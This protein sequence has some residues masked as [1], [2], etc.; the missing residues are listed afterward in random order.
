VI[1]R[2]SFSFILFVAGVAHLTRPDLFDPAIPFSFKIEINVA[3]GILEI[4]LAL[5]LCFSRTKDFAARLSA[6]WLLLLVPVHVYVSVFEIPILGVSHPAILW[7]RTAFQFVLYFWALSIQDKGWMIAQRWSDVL[8]LHYE[9]DASELQ[10]I[11]PYPVD[12][13]EGKAI[14]SI[15]PFAMSRIR[16]PFLPAIPGFSKLYEL[17]LRTYVRINNRPAVYFFTLDSNHLPG[18]LVARLGFSL[19][20]RLRKMNLINQ[21]EYKFK[22]SSL[23]VTAKISVERST[24]KF[25]AWSTER[26]ALVTK[27]FGR[28]LWGVVE[29]EKWKLQKVH[30]EHIEDHFSGEFIA[31]KKFIGASYASTLDVRFRPF[32][33]LGVL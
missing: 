4:F 7:G 22:A 25:D 1:S 26:Y 28:D 2:L 29:H 8:F 21:Q 13:F 15:V 9:V 10:K 12:L 33:F 32:H 5:G 24:N 31:V 17:N 11:V 18:V 14:V 6:L 30:V 27:F 3:A 19:P 23:E 16:F 20:Y